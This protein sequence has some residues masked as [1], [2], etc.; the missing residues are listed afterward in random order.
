SL[1][2]IHSTTSEPAVRYG[3]ISSSGRLRTGPFFLLHKSNDAKQPGAQGG[4][5]FFFRA[6]LIKRIYGFSAAGQGNVAAGE[7]GFAAIL[8]HELHQQTF[9]A[10]LRM[11]GI[12]EIEACGRILE[13]KIRTPRVTLCFSVPAGIEEGK[14]GPQDLEDI[15]LVSHR[16]IPG[17]NGEPK[18]GSER[19]QESPSGV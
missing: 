11:V 3:R 5:Q 10:G 17:G 1:Y 8:R 14:F 9:R 13:N 2:F 15:A 6:P 16:K 18:G 19:C 7:T 4:L 12:V